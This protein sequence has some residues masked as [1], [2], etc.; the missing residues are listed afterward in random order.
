MWITKHYIMYLIVGIVADIQKTT[1][2][3]KNRDD[4]L[5]GGLKGCVRCDKDGGT[6]ISS[7]GGSL[8]NATKNSAGSSTY[9]CLKCVHLIVIKTRQCVDTCPSGYSE[10]W[11]TMID[12]MGRICKES[13]VVAGVPMSGQK[14]AIFLGAS[15]GTLV[16]LLM[17]VSGVIYLKYRRNKTLTDKARRS[18]TLGHLTGTHRSQDSDD[19][20]RPEFLKQLA[21]LRPD[22]PVFLAML[23]E[24]RR[25]VRELR[26]PSRQ[27]SAM[28]AY[29]PVLKDLSRI[30]ILLNRPEDRIGVPPADWETLL[31]WGER[32]LR[33]Y[34]K[35]NPDQVAQLLGFTQ[36]P[37]EDSDSPILDPSPYPT[38]LT[39]FS[40]ST[41]CKLQSPRAS[42]N[43][44]QQLAISAFDEAYN[45]H[46]RHRGSED[47][48]CTTT[49][50][51]EEMTA[52]VR[53]SSLLDSGVDV[54]SPHNTAGGNRDWETEKSHS[55]ILAEWS[56]AAHMTSRRSCYYPSADEDDFY[57]L[58]FRP[59][60]EITTEL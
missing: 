9:R 58:G 25:Q 52:F 42:T 22:A 43:Q 10:E 6:V 1:V 56:S 38:H 3:A 8:S 20:E 45:N 37:V 31:A 13:M 34:K 5:C 36:L 53:P 47:E 51:R 18:P 7:E 48:D 30:L 16:C 27:N 2:A 4:Y 59:Q 29:R 50:K 12:Y 46:S 54:S 35:Q 24:T 28:Q 57:T 49:L 55:T 17:L 32:V 15:I 40:S 33:R 39:T 14:L 41:D 19:S 21:Y 11:S 44:L 60:D 26:R 23:N